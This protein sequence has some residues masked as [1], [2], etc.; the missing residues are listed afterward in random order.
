[1]RSWFQSL[2]NEQLEPGM[3]QF[4]DQLRNGQLLCKSVDDFFYTF[5]ERYYRLISVKLFLLKTCSWS[6]EFFK[7]ENW[8]PNKA[9]M[10]NLLVIY[11]Q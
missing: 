6:T 8:L 1:M 2:L 3:R 7:A 10:R 5:H 4:E 9:T 11:K